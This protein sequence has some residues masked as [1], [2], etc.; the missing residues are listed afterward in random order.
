M[1]K[2]SAAAF[3]L[4]GLL[5]GGLSEAIPADPPLP[6]GGAAILTW[7]PEQ[8]AFGYKNMEK[9]APVR[10][11][12]R[13]KTVHP[14]PP[15]SVQID[16][17]FTDGGKSYN[18]ESYMR[19]FRASGVLA[20]KNG[21]IVLERYGLGRSPT[22]RWTSFSVAKSVTSTLIGAAIKDGKIKSLDDR[23]TLY[24]PELKGSAYDDVTVRQLITMTSGVKWNESYTDP[25]SDVAKEGLSILEPGVN[26]VVSY[27]RRLPREA[28]PGAKFVYKTGETDLAGILLSNAVGEP[29]AQYLSD[30][31]WRPYGMER[32]GIWVEDV[33]GHERGGCCISMTLRDYGRVGQFML[34]HGVAD[35][36]EVVPAGWTEDA[37]ARH[38][39]DPPYGYFW[40]IVQGGYEAEG[41]FGQTLSMFPEDHL[42][43][44]INSAWP[45]AWSQ[46]IDAVRKKYVA[47]LR[48]AAR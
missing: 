9:I 25:N 28:A 41:I 36:H 14:L 16:P 27:M 11:I 5:G 22:E 2:K 37:T 39:A 29:L 40:W 32:D 3:A 4:A 19:E 15:A 26:P 38:V 18:T 48:A 42:V 6:P 17:T 7:T 35:G 1:M 43:V 34:D 21:K 13:G 12:K 8:Q 47:A 33:A 45:A 46:E 23:V 30:K 24:I 20:I 31:V 44:V 10:V